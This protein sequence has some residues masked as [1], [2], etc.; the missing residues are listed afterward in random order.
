MIALNRQYE[1]IPAAG[2]C[3]KYDIFFKITREMRY[4]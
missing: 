4:Y 1:K 3:V 2:K